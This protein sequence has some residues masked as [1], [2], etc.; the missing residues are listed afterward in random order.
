MIED[1]RPFAQSIKAAKGGEQDTGGT[2]SDPRGGGAGGR[3]SRLPCCRGAP[4]GV[5]GG[6]LGAAT[7]GL[8][9]PIEVAWHTTKWH[10]H[11]HGGFACRSTRALGGQ[12]RAAPI[13][14][15]SKLAPLVMPSN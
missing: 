10:E 12:P 15:W 4:L 1:D 11:M 14:W 2:D 8:P 9:I 7:V 13:A 3:P 5:V 6:L